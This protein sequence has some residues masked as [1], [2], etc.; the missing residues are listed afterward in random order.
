MQKIP[1]ALSHTKKNLHTIHF[2]NEG[3]SR[4]SWLSEAQWLQDCIPGSEMSLVGMTVSCSSWQK[5]VKAG[6]GRV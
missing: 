2:R 4:G 3:S 5:G 1:L 6:R